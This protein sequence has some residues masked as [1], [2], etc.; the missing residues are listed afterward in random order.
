MQYFLS[1]VVSNVHTEKTFQ[2]EPN[3]VL[4]TSDALRYTYRK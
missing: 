1:Q 3:D 2:L 4:H